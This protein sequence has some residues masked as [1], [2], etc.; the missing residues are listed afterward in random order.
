MAVHDNIYHVSIDY[1]VATPANKQINQ[2]NLD[3]A[4]AV[5]DNIYHVSIDYKVATAA[6]KQINQV[7]L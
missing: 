3:L 5:H 7:N 4:N 1:K 2:V 6:N